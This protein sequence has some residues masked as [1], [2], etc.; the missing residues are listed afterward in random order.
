VVRTRMTGTAQRPSMTS[1]PAPAS[2]EDLIH[3][4][5]RRMGSGHWGTLHLPGCEGAGHCR[6]RNWLV[7]S[8]H[9]RRSH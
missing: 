1:F 5:R 4:L 3:Q 7:R 8:S 6:I 9:D 2:S